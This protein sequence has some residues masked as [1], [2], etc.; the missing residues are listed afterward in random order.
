MTPSGQRYSE[1]VMLVSLRYGLERVIF[2]EPREVLDRDYPR[3]FHRILIMDFVA[4]QR[5]GH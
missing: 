4:D 2:K 3:D 5:A 1:V